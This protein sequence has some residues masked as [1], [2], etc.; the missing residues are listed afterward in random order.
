LGEERNTL[1]V[2]IY[3]NSGRPSWWN[4][5]VEVGSVSKDLY[6]MG[7]DNGGM[8][9]RIK[10]DFTEVWRKIYTIPGGTTIQ[11]GFDIASDESYLYSGLVN[12]VH[13]FVAILDTN[14]GSVSQA[15]YTNS[16][17]TS[18]YSVYS[19]SPDNTV[20]FFSTVEVGDG[21]MFI[22]KWI[23]GEVNFNCVNYSNIIRAHIITPIDSSIVVVNMISNI[24]PATNYYK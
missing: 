12:G 19:I 18:R 22:W 9:R 23:R 3:K 21:G 8:F 1:I 10:P 17:K 5:K 6:I 4:I 14:D 7:E 13:T 20:L 2:Q 24:Q 16:F 15:L 11:Y